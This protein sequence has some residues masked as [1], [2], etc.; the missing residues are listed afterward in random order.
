M[1]HKYHTIEDTVYFHFAVNDTSG[2]G[3]DGTTP[4]FDVRLNGAAAGAA[5][6]LSGTPT[7]LTSASY[8]PGAY[9]VSIAATVANGFAAGEEYAVFSTITADAQNPVGFIGGFSLSPVL[10]SSIS[11]SPASFMNDQVKNEVTRINWET[12]VNGVLTAPTVPGTAYALEDGSA[13]KISTGVTTVNNVGGESGVH[14]TSVDTSNAV[15]NPENAYQINL[16][17]M[18]LGGVADNGAAI[19]GFNLRAQSI[20]DIYGNGLIIL[21]YDWDTNTAST[22]P[23]AGN[24]KANNAT[25]SLITQIFIN[26]ATQKGVNASA[27]IQAL[28]VG[29][30][31]VIAKD[32]D[33][34]KF[35]DGVVN[36][37]IV[38]N[39]GWFTIPITIASSGGTI[40]NND[41]V[42]VGMFFVRSSLSPT[43]N[44]Q[45]RYRLQLDGTQVAPAVD[46]P[47][48]L[49][50]NVGA[51]QG[52][53]I[54]GAN[55]IENDAG[56]GRFTIQALEQAPGGGGSGLTAQETRD[57]MKLAPTAG[58]P[59]AGSVD[60][61]LDSILDDTGTSGVQ[62][63]DKS[64]YNVTSGGIGTVG[65]VTGNVNGSVNSVASPVTVGTNNDKT[66]YALAANITVKKGVAL[67]QFQFLMTDTATPPNPVTG[68]AVSGQ[69]VKDSGSFANLANPIAEIGLGWYRVNGG[70]TAS[71]TNADAFS[72]NF[73]ATGAATRGITILT[74]AE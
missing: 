19:A 56:D 60:Q 66:G 28:Q 23:L 26:G 22:D 52:L 17:G 11:I 8:A 39:G 42:D 68:L 64:G 32:K 71:E 4:L 73:T 70:F 40:A 12:R 38:D 27:L 20:D 16:E 41:N 24:V 14:T 67:P 3:I 45:L 54:P 9:E 61:E 43:E 63:A 5:P 44:S 48:Q 35:F 65:T 47:T 49:P 34:T 51:W 21:D 74:Q 13:T 37:G 2:S 58:A 31:I 6:V 25:Y 30:L 18:T 10:A 50:A 57:A 46:A 53:A 55:M 62:V 29:D 36:G 33:T 1:S 15:F 69:I 72:L 59:A 7:L